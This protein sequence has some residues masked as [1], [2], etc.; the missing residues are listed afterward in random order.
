MVYPRAHRT[1]APL[2]FSIASPR[3]AAQ[4]VKAT[5]NVM[6]PQAMTQGEH[7]WELLTRLS[8]SLAVTEAAYV[9]AKSDL[10]EE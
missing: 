10:R 8:T 3:E 7:C 1:T 6:H 9:E 2:P 5:R 4:K